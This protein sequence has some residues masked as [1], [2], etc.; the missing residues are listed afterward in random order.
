MD[1]G[2]IRCS[3]VKPHTVLAS[4]TVV[5]EGSMEEQLQEWGEEEDD[6]GEMQVLCKAPE[7]SG[8]TN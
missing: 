5:S 6:D 3:N 4:P 8:L 2:H 1:L 7:H